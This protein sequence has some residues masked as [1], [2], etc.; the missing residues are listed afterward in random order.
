[1]GPHPPV[2]LSQVIL[3]SCW[4]TDS[5]H[6]PTLQECTDRI[7]YTHNL[8]SMIPIHEFLMNNG[9]GWNLLE[10]CTLSCNKQVSSSPEY[11]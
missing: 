8:G 1:M 5:V 7:A 4:M 11:S 9:E 2:S 3:C 6:D 10:S